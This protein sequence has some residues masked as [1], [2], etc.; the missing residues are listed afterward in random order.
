[1]ASIP[2]WNAFGVLPP[3]QGGS[4]STAGR[5]PYEVALTDVMLHYGTSP[6]R[7]AI[8]DGFLRYR[9]ALHGAGLIA[10]FQ[11]LNGS[12]VE[13]VEDLEGRP[14]N[15]LDAVTFYHLPVGTTQAALAA[16]H[17]D[18]FIFD[19]ATKQRLK[20]NYRVDAFM[21][22]LGRAPEKLVERS[23]YWYSMWAHRRNDQWKGYLQVPLDPGQ[24][25]DAMDILNAV[26][27]KAPQP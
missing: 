11:W 6:E 4:L 23:W 25:Q 14:P 18:V 24:D 13:N 10:G 5:S 2:A 20:T 1:M 7:C 21:E 16:A 12:F 9:A 22:S 19:L 26:R 17:R 27:A 15:D 8:L 3:A